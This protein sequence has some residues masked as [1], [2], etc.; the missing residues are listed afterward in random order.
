MELNK[1]IVA[2]R[3]GVPGRCGMMMNCFSSVGLR[4]GVAWKV[5]CLASCLL[6]L[7]S[8]VKAQTWDEW[9]SQKKTQI[10]Y[11]EQQIAAL[12]VYGSYLKKGYQIA[13]KGL[14]NIRDMTGMEMALHGDHYAGLKRVNPL[15]RGDPA[16]KGTMTY[17]DAVASELDKL[18]A[19]S[20]LDAGTRAYIASVRKKVLSECTADIQ[21]LDTVVNS[22]EVSMTDDERIAKL[23]VLYE[24]SKSRYAFTMS[25]GSQV[26]DLLRERSLELNNGQIMRGLYGIN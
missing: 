22:G 17:T 6:I 14:G 9:W 18:Y 21:E 4:F 1:G 26:E 19:L 20:G 11:L 23:Q 24:R 2:V 8:D 10:K 7:A 25:F 13:D 5:L 16:V 15:I 12:Q 3:C